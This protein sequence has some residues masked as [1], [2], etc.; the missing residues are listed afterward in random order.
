MGERGIVGGGGGVRLME[1]SFF[2]VLVVSGDFSGERGGVW[3]RDGS[4]CCMYVEAWKGGR[5]LGRE[6]LGCY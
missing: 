1:L 5:W 2:F 6:I 4:G 3:E